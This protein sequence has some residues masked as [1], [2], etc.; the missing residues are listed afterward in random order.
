MLAAT[1]RFLQRRKRRREISGG[2]GG[3]GGGRRN[4]PAGTTT[5]EETGKEQL[6]EEISSRGQA[7]NSQRHLSKQLMGVRPGRYAKQGASQRVDA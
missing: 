6:V 3:G 2:G 4:W 7:R 5:R 1:W